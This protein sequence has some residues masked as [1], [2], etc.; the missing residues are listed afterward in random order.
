M[1]VED[2]EFGNMMDGDSDK[3]PP[4]TKTV[5]QSV[6]AI[7]IA[8]TVGTAVVLLLRIHSIWSLIREIAWLVATMGSSVYASTRVHKDMAGFH[9]WARLTVSAIVF[10]VVFGV[11]GTALGAYHF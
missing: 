7:A 10:L 8:L 9:N 5:G 2:E 3:E 4:P 6:V 11:I 1:G